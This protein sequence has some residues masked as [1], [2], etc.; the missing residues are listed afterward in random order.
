MDLQPGQWD[1]PGTLLAKVAQ[2]GKL[3]A[4]LRIPE[5]QAADVQDGQ[6]CSVDL[7]NGLVDGHVT[8]IEA[9]A[10]SGTVGVDSRSMDRCRRVHVPT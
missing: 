6:P 3:K 9:S 10:Q 7:R 4:E 5:N 2:P 8:R 1:Q